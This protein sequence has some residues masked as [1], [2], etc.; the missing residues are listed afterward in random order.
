MMVFTDRRMCIDYTIQDEN[1]ATA[2]DH[3]EAIAR[4]YKFLVSQFDTD[5]EIKTL[6]V[7]LAPEDQEQGVG[8]AIKRKNASLI[9]QVQQAVEQLKSDGTIEGYAN[10]WGIS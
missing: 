2:L 8:I 7:P 9:K 3:V 5:S 4:A 1:H 10:K 6:D